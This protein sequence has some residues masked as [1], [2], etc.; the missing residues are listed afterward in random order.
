MF[1]ISLESQQL[2]DRIV[3]TKMYAYSGSVS[4]LLFLCG[5]LDFELNNGN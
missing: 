5:F 3:H 2:L 4:L 1:E